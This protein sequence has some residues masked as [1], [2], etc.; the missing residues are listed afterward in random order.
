MPGYNTPAERQRHMIGA[1]KSFCRRQ[2][3]YNLR[4]TSLKR[5]ISRIA[6]HH[7]GTPGLMQSSQAVSGRAILPGLETPTAVFIPDTV[8]N[9]IMRSLLQSS[10]L[11][12]MISSINRYI[13][14]IAP[15]RRPLAPASQHPPTLETRRAP[16]IPLVEFERAPLRL[17]EM[18]LHRSFL[19]LN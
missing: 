15:D 2:F 6:P 16:I 17:Q 11:S 4:D 3:V 5:Q 13:V 18:R 19:V 9:F 7:S 12:S 1:G 10:H 14:V 8:V